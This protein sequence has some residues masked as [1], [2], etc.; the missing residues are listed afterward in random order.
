METG[1][2]VW[3]NFIKYNSNYSEENDE[4]EKKTID[5]EFTNQKAGPE[6]MKMLLTLNDQVYMKKTRKI[7]LV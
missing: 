5:I 4:E 1:L 3:Q 7:L 2:P 6:V